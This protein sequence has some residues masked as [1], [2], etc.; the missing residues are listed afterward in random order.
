[1]LNVSL[2]IYHKQ[3][4]TLVY[5]YIYVCNCIF[6][7]AKLST[8]QIIGYYYTYLVEHMDADSVSHLMHIKDLITDDDFEAISFSPNDMIM[9]CLLLQYVKLMTVSTLFKFCNLLQTI[10]TQK[11]IFHVLTTGKEH[12][13][14]AQRA[15]YF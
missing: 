4:N 3:N 15:Y 10:E 7:T 5:I 6:F 13:Y 14:R 8:S 11:Y 9:N 1:M 2:F 12:I